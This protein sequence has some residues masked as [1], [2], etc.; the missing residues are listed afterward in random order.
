MGARMV[1]KVAAFV[2]VTC[3]L[4][5]GTGVLSRANVSGNTMFTTATVTTFVK[6]YTVKLLTGC[7]VTLTPKVKL[8]TFF[9]CAMILKVKC[10]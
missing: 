8:G 2:A 3:V 10:D 4:I 1:T 9:T 5:M 7:P 6:D